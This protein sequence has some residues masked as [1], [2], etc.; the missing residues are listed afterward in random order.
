MVAGV[1]STVALAPSVLE[2]LDFRVSC[3]LRR[4]APYSVGPV[5][6]MKDGENTAR[7]WEQT[8]L[9]RWGYESLILAVAVQPGCT[10]LGLGT[11]LHSRTTADDE[12][13]WVAARLGIGRMQMEDGKR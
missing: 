13:R 12:G 8:E 1:P 9:P 10:N 2:R 5:R 11:L 3:R 4:P 6:T 7:D